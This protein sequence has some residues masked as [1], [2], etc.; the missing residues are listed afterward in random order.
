MSK[1]NLLNELKAERKIIQTA[2]NFSYIVF[3]GQWEK[4]FLNYSNPGVIELNLDSSKFTYC[5]SKPSDLIQLYKTPGI[6]NNDVMDLVRVT[7]RNAINQ[8]YEKIQSFCFVDGKQQ[9]WEQA[10]FR[11]LARLVRNSMSHDFILNF[12]DSKKKQLHADVSFTFPSGKTLGIK[13]SEHEKPITGDN[14]PLDSVL[15]LLDVMENF[16]EKEL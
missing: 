11:P 14:L 15:A 12:W 1:Q 13:N 16:V 7:I 2:L 8:F 9:K 5:I 4:Q 3:C 6:L 10:S